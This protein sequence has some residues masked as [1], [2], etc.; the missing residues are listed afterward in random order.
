MVV[1][2]KAAKVKTKTARDAIAIDDFTPPKAPP[3]LARAYNDITC[4]ETVFDQPDLSPGSES[5]KV[6]TWRAGA[7]DRL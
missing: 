4:G 3:A 7:C 2:M 5:W 1:A 6:S